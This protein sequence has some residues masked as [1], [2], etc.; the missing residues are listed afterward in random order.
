MTAPACRCN[1]TSELSGNE[2]VDYIEHLEYVTEEDDGWL[3]RCPDLLVEWIAPYIPKGS[4]PE[5]FAL[6]RRTDD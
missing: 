3:F 2:A 5:D 6:R 1:K 4:S